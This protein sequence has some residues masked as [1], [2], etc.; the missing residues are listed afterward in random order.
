MINIDYRPEILAYLSTPITWAIAEILAFI[1]FFY[2]VVDVLKVKDEKTRIFRV[3]ELFGFIVYAGIFENIGVLGNTYNYSFDRLVMFGVVPL[4]ILMFEAA[5]FY[6]ALK[7]AEALKFPKWATPIVV[8]FLGVLQDLTIDPA[9][10]FDLYIV[11]GVMEGRWNWTLHYDGMLF[12]IPFFNFTG[13]FLLMF[14]YTTL[15]LVGRK[16]FEKSG[17]K[18]SRGWAY[19]IISPLVGVLLIISPLTQFLLF[20]YPFFPLYLNRTVEIVMLSLIAGISL[21]TIFK[22]RKLKRSETFSYKENKVIWVVPVILH[23]FD[24]ILAFSLGITIAYVP[25]L[26]FA[27]IHL[28]YLAFYIFRKPKSSDGKI[29]EKSNEMEKIPI[30]IA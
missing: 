20:L 19:V 15:I 21:A 18:S 6:S 1:I 10:V 5:I 26:L 8:G 13:W 7:F 28:G 27:G 16:L 23:A 14:Y 9:A 2:C 22:F 24:I 17:N 3:F 11:N 25:V 4:S 29:V 12:G 30:D